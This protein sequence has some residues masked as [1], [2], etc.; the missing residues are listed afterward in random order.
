M[1]PKN[2]RNFRL[3]PMAGCYLVFSFCYSTR[4]RERKEKEGVQCSSLLPPFTFPSFFR[5]RKLN[6]TMDKIVND[7][8]WQWRWWRCRFVH[9][10]TA[11]EWIEWI[12][13]SRLYI[14]AIILPIHTQRRR[15]KTIAKIVSSSWRFGTLSRFNGAK[16][17]YFLVV[18]PSVLLH[19]E[20]DHFCE[21]PKCVHAHTHCHIVT[22]CFVNG[23]FDDACQHQRQKTTRK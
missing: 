6:I 12:F 20:C 7:I 16:C 3:K 5:C 13:C 11:D 8:K 14:A 17:F 10:P 22:L 4:C 18:S 21:L 15:T 19:V 1:R 2:E 23:K 9:S